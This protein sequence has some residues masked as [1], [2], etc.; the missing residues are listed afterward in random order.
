MNILRILNRENHC[1]NSEL[2]QCCRVS[3]IGGGAL[4]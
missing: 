1:V 2:T 3:G 4:I